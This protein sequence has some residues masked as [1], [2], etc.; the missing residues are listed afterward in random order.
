MRDITDFSAKASG[1]MTKNKALFDEALTEA[2]QDILSF[3]EARMYKSGIP[4]TF[5]KKRTNDKNFLLKERDHFSNKTNATKEFLESHKKLAETLKFGSTEEDLEEEVSGSLGLEILQV[6]QKHGVTG[7][8]IEKVFKTLNTLIGKDPNVDE[9]I[10]GWG[11]AE[12]DESSDEPEEGS[13]ED[14]EDDTSD[15][16][17]EEDYGDD[18]GSDESVEESRMKRYNT[19]EE[20]TRDIRKRIAERRILESARLR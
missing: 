6:L 2:D 10:N 18:E 14:Y 13:D 3:K 5:A 19:L 4:S 16:E 11:P 9:L 7:D 12:D 17:S 1:Y 20:M 8:A 15:E